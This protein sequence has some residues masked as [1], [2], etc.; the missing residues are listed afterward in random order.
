[1]NYQKEKY[2]QLSESYKTGRR[3]IHDIK[4]QNEALKKYIKN[5]EYEALDNYLT[6]YTDST[7]STYASVCT[8][9]LVIDSLITNY[10]NIAS[11]KKSNLQLL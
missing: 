4:Y 10:H 6:A 7:K 2:L 8:G 1:M 11:S 5:H 3:I 9:N